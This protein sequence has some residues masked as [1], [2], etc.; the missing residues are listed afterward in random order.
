MLT[1]EFYDV[2]CKELDYRIFAGT[3][4]KN[5]HLLY[6]YM[7]PTFMH[8]VPTVTEMIAVNIMTGVN[9]AGKNGSVFIDNEQFTMLYK[10]IRK[11]IDSLKTNLL[12]ITNASI[13]ANI[14]QIE[15]IND[16]SIFSVADILKSQPCC[17]IINKGI[18]SDG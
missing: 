2:M 16:K 7:S 6:K 17:L 18:L 10:Q 5:F 4:V 15:L 11:V 1:T 9:I 8:Y 13:Y 12:F 3:P 14:A